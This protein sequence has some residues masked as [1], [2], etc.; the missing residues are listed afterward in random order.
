MKLRQVTLRTALALLTIAAIFLFLNRRFL[1]DAPYTGPV[2]DIGDGGTEIVYKDDDREDAISVVVTQVMTQGQPTWKAYSG[3]PPLS[4]RKALEIADK[5]RRTR[6][7]EQENYDWALKC[8][9]LTPLDSE[10]GKWCW[11]VLFEA[12]ATRGVGSSGFWPE[13]PVYVLMDGE[14]I[15]PEDPGNVLTRQSPTPRRNE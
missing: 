13:F 11:V 4:A 7:R 5:F 15:E 3:N 6:F 10:N 14:V 1:R 8:A 9:S 12:N 2:S